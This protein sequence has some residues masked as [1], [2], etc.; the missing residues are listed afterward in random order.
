[1]L[2]KRFYQFSVL[3]VF[4]ITILTSGCV[5]KSKLENKEQLVFIETTLGNIKI[6]LYNTTP[7]HR[8][9]FLK[10]VNEG[11]YDGTLFHRVIKEFMVQGGDPDS[12][13]AKS[14]DVLGNGGPEYTIPA[15]FRPGLFHKKGALA[16]ARKS[17]Q[18]NPE[19]RSSGS[20]FYI[21]QGKVFTDEELDKIE[22]KINN[23]LKQS[24]FFKF[25]E[26]EKKKALE[27]DGKID[28][29]KVQEAAALKTEEEFLKMKAYTI[30]PEQRQVYKT[31][32]GTPHLDQNYT[33]FG[34]VVEGLEVID[35]ITLV[36][37]DERDR[38]LEDI[39]ILQ[40]KTVK[41]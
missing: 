18:V 8:D 40:M 1:M 33:V 29:S 10:L 37:T 31:S 39:K 22:D 24:V 27:N 11:Y 12:K 17:D 9:N 21:V 30:P 35:K 2:F 19:K 34:Q 38:A 25:V 20:Q 23:M 14:G 36:K 32:G 15:E 6:K 13:T 3:F 28:Y 16:A 4:S 5:S 7:L 26:D 41:K